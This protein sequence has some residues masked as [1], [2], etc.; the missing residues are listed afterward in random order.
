MIN[1][2]PGQKY[3]IDYRKSRRACFQ[4]VAQLKTPEALDALAKAYSNTAITVTKL[5]EALKQKN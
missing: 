1:L 2:A 3:L 4:S 5:A